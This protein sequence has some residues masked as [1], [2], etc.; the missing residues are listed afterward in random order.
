MPPQRFRQEFIGSWGTDAAVRRFVTDDVGGKLG[1][2]AINSLSEA[3]HRRAW[4]AEVAAWIAANVPWTLE[5]S[6]WPAFEARWPGL[7]PSD[8]EDIDTELQR[9]GD[10]ICSSG[11]FGAVAATLSGRREY[12][13]A[14]AIW[15]RSRFPEADIHH[16][17]FCE[18][19]GHLTREELLL[20]AIEHRR[21]ICAD[22]RSPPQRTVEP[23]ATI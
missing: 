23:R 20:A 21:L 15:L 22:E 18:R 11:D 7:T 1:G 13:S 19:F 14:A 12:W 16:P 6:E 4:I 2:M 9:R 17:E 10:A 8:L 5:A 3:R